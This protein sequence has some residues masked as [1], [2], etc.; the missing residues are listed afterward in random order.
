VTKHPRRIVVAALLVA[1]SG[2]ALRAQDRPAQAPPSPP[3]SSPPTPFP[4]PRSDQP[5]PALVPLKVQVV[6]ARYKG[7]ARISSMP[8]TMVVNANDGW[9]GKRPA[10]LRTGAQVPLATTT[11]TPVGDG[12]TPGTSPI[13]SYQYQKVGTNIDCSATS[14]DDGRYKLEISIDDTSVYPDNRTGQAAAPRPGDLPTLNNFRFDN[15]LLLKDGQTMQFTAATDK[16]TG[17]QTRI[18]VTLNVVK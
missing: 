17:E 14:T 4:V 3:A 2:L 18:D 13:T 9:P 8:Y 5:K 16:V 7:E 15:S 6:I 12:K 1:A 11:F 10:S